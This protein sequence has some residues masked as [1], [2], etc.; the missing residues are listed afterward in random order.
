MYIP[1]T[2]RRRSG[3]TL[4]EL[5][6]VIAIIVILVALLLSGI[7]YAYSRMKE[8]GAVSEVKQLDASLQAFKA[9][10]GIYPVSRIR[11]CS[12][13]AQYT[14]SPTPN[15]NGG[16]ALDQASISFINRMWPNIGAWSNINWA[17]NGSNVDEILEG[18]QCLVFFLGGIPTPSNNSFTFNGFSVN[19]K[20]PSAVNSNAGI[21]PPFYAFPFDR[22]YLRNGNNFP[23]FSDYYARTNPAPTPYIFFSAYNRRNGYA[24]SFAQPILGVSPYFT[25]N[26]QYLNPDTCQIICAGANGNYGAGGQW[27][28]QTADTIYPAGS[29]GSDDL[30]NFYPSQMGV[31]Q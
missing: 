10:Y 3:F 15:A 12:N 16:V 19:P 6:I 30:T 7:F 13:Y 21:V 14:N 5:L 24:P 29:A 23:S 17:G 9:K 25:S 18:D 31:V 11:L 20:D 1:S 27:T 2:P 8:A 28:P 22:V 26:G 4:I